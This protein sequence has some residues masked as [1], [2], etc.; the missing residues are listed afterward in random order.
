MQDLISILLLLSIALVFYSRPELRKLKCVQYWAL[1]KIIIWS[2]YVVVFKQWRVDHIN[3]HFYF[4]TNISGAILYTL[5]I[6]ELVFHF[7]KKKIW[8]IYLTTAL[9]LL[10]PTFE[11]LRY[12]ERIYLTYAFANFF[13][14][15]EAPRALK[16]KNVY[17]ISLSLA[18]FWALAI[19]VLKFL[20]PY[21]QALLVFRQFEGK[22]GLIGNAVFLMAALWYP[23]TSWVYKRLGFLFG[24]S[25]LEPVLANANGFFSGSELQLQSLSGNIKRSESNKAD[26]HEADGAQIL[27]FPGSFNATTVAPLP[28]AVK[29]VQVDVEEI[30]PALESATRMMALSRKPF[31]TLKETA[32]YLDISEEEA[33]AFIEKYNLNPLYLTED[34]R[35]WV[36]KRLDIDYLLEEDN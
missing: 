1:L 21:D 22:S 33:R 8:W 35:E 4:F 14:I 30:K 26:N 15:F 31:L 29:D 32:D 11:F 36:I 13:V 3:W 9:I 5:A 16:E 18:S 2:V 20:L 10:T 24:A 25:N 7:F 17:L 6:R 19:D 27:K 34:S 12:V 28:D 23:V